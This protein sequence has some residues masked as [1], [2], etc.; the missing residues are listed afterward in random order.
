MSYEAERFARIADEYGAAA[1]RLR[2][3]HTCSEDETA[4]WYH[5]GQAMASR[6]IAAEIRHQASLTPPK[7][8]RADG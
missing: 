7:G 6:I 5:A 3:A 1:S 2:V 4:E 8:E